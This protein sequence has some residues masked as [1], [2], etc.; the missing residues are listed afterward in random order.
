MSSRAFCAIWAV[1][2]H[3]VAVAGLDFTGAQ[4]IWFPDR[5]ADGVTY[6][7]GNATFRRDYYPPAGQ[8][9]LSAEILVSVDDDFTLFVNG[10]QI[11]T[12]SLIA[13]RFCVPLVPDCNV[14]AIQAENRP[15]PAPA[16]SNTGNK[17]GVIAAI[18]V[19]YSNG[20]TD[21]IVTDNQWH[22]ILGA[23]AGFAQVA[24]DD[25]AWPAPFI[26]G[27]PMAPGAVP[28]TM[29]LPAENQ[30]PGPDLTAASWIWSLDET[31]VATAPVGGVIFRKVVT[32]PPGQY[33]D[34]ITM[35]VG[36]D[37]QYTM[38]INGQVVGSGTDYQTTK[39]Y[40]VNFMPSNTITIAFYAANAGG[41]G[42]L[43]ASGQIKGCACGCGNTA[44]V[45]TDSTWKFSSATPFPTSFINPGFDDSSWAQAISQGTYTSATLWNKPAPPTKN[46]PQGGPVPG[47]PNAPPATVVV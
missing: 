19:R 25:S 31:K 21:T 17:A 15:L 44:R 2:V 36:C 29:T 34:T 5:D 3:L 12:G 23:P 33:A 4:V 35:D 7:A 40:Q 43:I 14:F 45:N 13:Y 37:D 32:L 10:A 22:A 42:W 39:R 20:F 18:K 6:P 46:S 26:E 16:K 24:F 9:P 27:A 11:G 47:A 8:T 28:W 1:A 38:Y 30:D 41:P